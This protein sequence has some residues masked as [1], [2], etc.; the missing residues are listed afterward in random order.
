MDKQLINDNFS[1]S[2]ISY[3]AYASVQKKCADILLSSLGEE[4]FGRILEI[5]CGTGIYTDI[6]RKRYPDAEITAVDISENMLNIAKKKLSSHNISFVNTDAEKLGAIEKAD[7]ITSNATLQWFSDLDSSFKSFADKLRP[8]GKLA[9][10]IYGPETF[11]EFKS[12]LSERYGPGEWLSSSKFP[13]KN[14]LME[15]LAEY[16]SSISVEELSFSLCFNSL[17]EFMRDIQ[18]T[19]ARGEGLGEDIF[20]GRYALNDLEKIYLEKYGT[21][22]VTHQV[23]LCEG[24]L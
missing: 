16:F 18:G 5:G 4:G 6:L 1:K 11:R 12:V 13:A 7:L 8:G 3:D 21:I 23:H 24:K 19:G 20:L 22:E 10:T 17:I 14:V 2:A 9:I 15:V